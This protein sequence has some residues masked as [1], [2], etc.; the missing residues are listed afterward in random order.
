VILLKAKIQRDTLFLHDHHSFTV[1]E[2]I[3][4]LPLPPFYE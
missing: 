4:V 2:A 1:L 3:I